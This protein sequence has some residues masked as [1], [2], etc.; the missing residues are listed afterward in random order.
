MSNLCLREGLVQRADMLQ[1]K[2]AGAGGC[3]YL[4]K[5]SLLPTCAQEQKDFHGEKLVVG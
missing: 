5:R 2:A 4:I 3:M 1:K